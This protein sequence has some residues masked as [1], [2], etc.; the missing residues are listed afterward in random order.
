MDYNFIADPHV[1]GNTCDLGQ[2]ITEKDF[3]PSP[4]S[5]RRFLE[6]TRTRG[7]SLDI[8]KA[9]D[10]FGHYGRSGSHPQPDR[11]LVDRSHFRPIL[12]CCDDALVDCLFSNSKTSAALDPSKEPLTLSNL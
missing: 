3:Q 10:G 4:L 9:G 8:S 11:L 1:A 5:K 12:S 2:T 6:I 7:P